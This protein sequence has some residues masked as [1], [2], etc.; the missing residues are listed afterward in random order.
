MNHEQTRTDTNGNVAVMRETLRFIVNQIDKNPDR[1]SAGQLLCVIGDKAEAALAE[2]PRNCDNY[3]N[4]TD[5]EIGFVEETGEDDRAQHY[6]QMF[7]NWLAKRK[8]EGDA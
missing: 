5:A 4:K 2:P 3:D 8:G 1:L 7:A 6:W